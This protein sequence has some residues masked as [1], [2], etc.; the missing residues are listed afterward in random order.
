MQEISRFYIVESLQDMKAP[1]VPAV[2]LEPFKVE[3]NSG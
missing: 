1:V 3:S 2:D